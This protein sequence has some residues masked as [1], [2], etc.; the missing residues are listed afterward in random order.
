MAA[1]GW[2]PCPSGERQ[3]RFFDGASWTNSL[4]P[5]VPQTQPL[6]QH[7]TSAPPGVEHLHRAHPQRASQDGSAGNLSSEAPPGSAQAGKFGKLPTGKRKLSALIAV[8]LVLYIV[9]QFARLANDPDPGSIL[10]GSLIVFLVLAVVLTAVFL[11]LYLSS[12][13]T[14]LL[15]APFGMPWD[16][17][18]SVTGQSLASLG[19]WT[20]KKVSRAPVPGRIAS[21]GSR[22]VFI[23]NTMGIGKKA[24]AAQL[25]LAAVRQTSSGKI[26]DGSAFLKDSATLHLRDTEG[27]ETDFTMVLMS[28]KKAAA[29]AAGPLGRFFT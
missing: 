18:V 5:V 6:Q 28:S 10:V 26:S 3:L 25:D 7:A 24:E 16:L 23:P 21:D 11:P 27:R 9:V 12:K 17:G 20:G 2:Y 15:V 13:K 4:R 19:C 29:F 22:L 1:A 8:P 14:K